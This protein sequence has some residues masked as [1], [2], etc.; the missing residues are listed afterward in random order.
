M[1][2]VVKLRFRFFSGLI[3]DVFSPVA[4]LPMVFV[5]FEPARFGLEFGRNLL[6]EP[7]F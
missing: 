2:P 6:L 3:S 4:D 5:Q 1:A 7:F